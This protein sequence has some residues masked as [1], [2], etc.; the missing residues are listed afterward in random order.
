MRTNYSTLFKSRDY[1]DLNFGIRVWGY[2]HALKI[3]A[4]NPNYFWYHGLKNETQWMEGYKKMKDN[5]W[6]ISQRFFVNDVFI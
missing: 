5:G 2:P 6:K 1:E 4:L 3:M